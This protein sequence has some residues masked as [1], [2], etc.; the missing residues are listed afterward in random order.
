MT[1]TARASLEATAPVL[2]RAANETGDAVHAL[3]SFSAHPSI[4][5]AAG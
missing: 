1:G 3:S 5:I 2:L 4:S